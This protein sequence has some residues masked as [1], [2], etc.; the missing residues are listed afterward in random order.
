[1]QTRIA[2]TIKGN[3]EAWEEYS[4]F[5]TFVRWKSGKL[6]VKAQLHETSGNWRASNSDWVSTDDKRLRFFDYSAVPDNRKWMSSSSYCTLRKWQREEKEIDLQFV[7]A[8][9]G[10]NGVVITVYLFAIWELAQNNTYNV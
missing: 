6:Q 5:R 3:N 4:Y 2:V 1:M 9:K 7:I 10:A 8:Q